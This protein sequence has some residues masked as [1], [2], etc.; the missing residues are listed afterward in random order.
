MELP[1]PS[2]RYLPMA[3]FHVVHGRQ[4]NMASKDGWYVKETDGMTRVIDRRYE[5]ELEAKA[6]AD[7]LTKME[8]EYP[9]M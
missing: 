3:T 6:V 2:A 5:T 9:S 8:A 7:R 1:A 4:T